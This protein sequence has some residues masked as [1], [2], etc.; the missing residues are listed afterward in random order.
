LS[1]FCQDY[2]KIP[3]F[4]FSP[5]LDLPVGE[6]LADIGSSPLVDLEQAG[7]GDAVLLEVG[8]GAICRENPEAQAGQDLGGAEE[9][10]LGFLAADRQEDVFLRQRE[11]RREDG[12]EIGLVDVFS[13]A[14]D[15]PAAAGIGRPGPFIGGRGRA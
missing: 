10:V 3:L 13:E 15:L 1:G 7:R 12:L 8:R 5:V 9:A 2:V 6:V 4:V 14:G 11:P